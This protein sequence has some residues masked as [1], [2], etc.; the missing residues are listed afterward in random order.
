MARAP[1]PSSGWKLGQTRYS[2]SAPASRS[3]HGWGAVSSPSTTSAPSASSS[4]RGRRPATTARTARPRPRSART[5]AVPVGPPAAVTTITLDSS[6]V[7][8]LARQARART[9]SPQPRGQAHREAGR[10]GEEVD[11][12]EEL[13]GQPQAH[14]ATSQVEA[15][16]GDEP[17]QRV[18]ERRP[19]VGD[20]ADHLAAVAPQPAGDRPL[21][22]PEGVGRHLADAQAEILQL[23]LVRHEG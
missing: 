6:A 1:S 10:P 15:V 3:R 19:A 17:G 12:V 22:V 14:A 21:A 18:V 8:D 9:G 13:A 16:R 2:A 23:H 5:T 20:G 7:R 11:V 4:G